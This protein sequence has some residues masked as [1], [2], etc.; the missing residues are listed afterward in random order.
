M[1]ALPRPEKPVKIGAS[2]DTCRRPL[3]FRYGISLV[4]DWSREGTGGPFIRLFGRLSLNPIAT[5]VG[6]AT[7]QVGVKRRNDLGAFANSCGDAFY[8]FRPDIA[9]GEHAA[10]GRFEPMTD[11]YGFAVECSSRLPKTERVARSGPK[12]STP[13]IASK[14]AS[15]ARARLTRLLMVPTTQPL[16]LAASW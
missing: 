16:I 3:A 15:R 12:S 4:I 13:S 10:P 11:L 14:P 8:R 1:S 9:D 6:L 7:C 2:P 5:E